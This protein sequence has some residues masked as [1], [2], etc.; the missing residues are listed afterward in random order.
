MIW[1]RWSL[2]Q[3]DYCQPQAELWRVAFVSMTNRSVNFQITY[4]TKAFWSHK[5]LS[6]IIK[7]SSI[8]CCQVFGVIQFRSWSCSAKAVGN[9][10]LIFCYWFIILVEFDFFD[11]FPSAFGGWLLYF[12]IARFLWQTPSLSRLRFWCSFS[13]FCR[14]RSWYWLSAV[15]WQPLDCNGF[16]LLNP[17]GRRLYNAEICRH[18]IHKSVR[19]VSHAKRYHSR[20]RCCYCNERK[21]EKDGQAMELLNKLEIEFLM[22]W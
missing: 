19:N 2:T 4:S 20:T 15:S 22:R 18:P 6:W 12:F 16:T 14:Y 9:Q 7:S 13:K 10:F 21:E 17:D 1:L 11:F 5:Q 3:P 8:R